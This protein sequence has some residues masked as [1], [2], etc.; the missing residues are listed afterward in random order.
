[1]TKQQS[2]NLSTMEN[3]VHIH[4]E[5]I[6]NM[7][8]NFADTDSNFMYVSRLKNLIENIDNEMTSV[9]H[10]LGENGF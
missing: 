2:D 1:M 6:W 4:L 3:K 9:K 7:I 10:I 5:M 8:N